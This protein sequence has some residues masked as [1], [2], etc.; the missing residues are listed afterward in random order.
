MLKI[1]SESPNIGVVNGGFVSGEL[2]KWLQR[3]LS[4]SLQACFEV[5]SVECSL[6][7]DRI[8]WVFHFLRYFDVAL[9]ILTS[10]VSTRHLV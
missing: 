8:V 5:K 2:V 1:T 6:E 9:N 4:L 10:M 7:W 3:C